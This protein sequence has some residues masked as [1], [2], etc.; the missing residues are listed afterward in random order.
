MP[1]QPH[2]IPAIVVTLTGDA[3]QTQDGGEIL[4][5]VARRPGPLGRG[6]RQLAVA[7]QPP[8]SVLR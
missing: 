4:A 8:P 1:P 6:A 7:R 5:P 2:W 3:S